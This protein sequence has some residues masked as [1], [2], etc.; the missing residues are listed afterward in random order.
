MAQLVL[1]RHGQSANNSLPDYERIPDPGLTDVGKQ[2]AAHTARAFESTPVARIYC[3]AFLRAL[4]TARPLAEV[5]KQP[6]FVRND[7]FEQGGCYAGHDAIG[8]R[9]AAGMG[10]SELKQ[11]YPDWQIDES[12]AEAGWWNR[13]YETPQQARTRAKEVAHWMRSEPVAMGGT[14]VFVIHADFKFLLLHALLDNQANET[15]NLQDPLFNTGIS[16][17]HWTGNA[18]QL[19]SLNEVTHL[20][21]DL[22]TPI[23]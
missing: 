17:F 22:V 10:M 14:H 6:V 13:D 3:S 7:I 1:I 11:A 9:G 12:I 21:K 15:L 20:P 8:K 2:Q 16:R 18:W 23:R 4:E 19:A 5:C